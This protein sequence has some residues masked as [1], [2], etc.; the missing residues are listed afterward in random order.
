MAKNHILKKKH[1][2]ITLTVI[3]PNQRKIKK[4]CGPVFVHDQKFVE[5]RTC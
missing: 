5:F 1:L 3:E 4:V 2:M